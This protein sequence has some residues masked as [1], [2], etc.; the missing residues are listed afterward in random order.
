M[1][2]P[3]GLDTGGLTQE[4]SKKCRDQISGELKE[5]YLDEL[6]TN[7]RPLADGNGISN[8]RN[9]IEID[10]KGFAYTDHKGAAILTKNSNL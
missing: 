5:N 3:T 1:V 8:I 9:F 4:E 10:S 7:R 2:D 6:D